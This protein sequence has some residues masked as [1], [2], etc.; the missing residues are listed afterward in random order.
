MAHPRRNLTHVTV[1]MDGG[2]GCGWRTYERLSLAE[3]AAM[4]AEP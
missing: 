1:W 2:D 4:Q 3:L